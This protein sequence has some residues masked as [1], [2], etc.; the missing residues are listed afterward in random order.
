MTLNTLAFSHTNVGNKIQTAFIQQPH[1][2]IIQYKNN[3]GWP[4]F[5]E[6]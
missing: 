4:Q 3:H 6:R 5:V 1:A 2:Q